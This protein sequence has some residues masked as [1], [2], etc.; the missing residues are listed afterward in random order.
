M[1]SFILALFG[2]RILPGEHLGVGK[3]GDVLRG[4]WRGSSGFKK[5]VAVKTLREGATDE[6]RLGLLQEAAIMAQF[7]HP[8]LTALYGVSVDSSNQVSC[9]VISA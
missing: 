4:V 3:F 6:D 5:D 1:E 8:N 9:H 2:F 7:R